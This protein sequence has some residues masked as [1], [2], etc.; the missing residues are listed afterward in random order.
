MKQDYRI[1]YID[2]NRRQLFVGEQPEGGWCGYT[3]TGKETPRRLRCGYMD[4]D[5]YTTYEEAQKAL[6]LYIANARQERYGNWEV[7]VNGKYVDWDE[8]G[9]IKMGR[10]PAPALQPPDALVTLANVEYRI[11]VH[12]QGAYENL[13]EVGKALLE[14]KSLNLVPH[15]QWE[16]WVEKNTGMSERSAQ[17]LMQAARST[18]SG[19]MMSK[20]P[21][22]KIQA[23]LALPEED[24]EPMA[25]KAVTENLS[26][27]QLQDEIRAQKDRIAALEGINKRA[28]ERANQSESNAR[29]ARVMADKAI[30]KAQEAERER[31]EARMAMEEMAGETPAAPATGISAEAQAMIDS[32]ERE[33]GQLSAQLAD[34]EKMAEYQARQREEAQQQLLDLRTQAARG[35]G[36]A[37]EDLTAEAVSMA[38]RTFIGCVGYVPHSDKLLTLREGD[39]QEI[40]AWAETLQRW[41]AD[42]LRVIDSARQAVVIEGV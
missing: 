3:Q 42:V 28:N 24:R 35:E 11:A 5:G 7:L 23:I 10:M 33:K 25:E 39:R 14:A 6:D 2:P 21:V 8:L 20:L 40:V 37:Q 41:S 17:R 34:A 16:A 4:R 30:K 32:L 31:D 18:P 38:A 36:P 26:L 9:Q 22:S 13:L 27:R 29:Q 1:V 15:G 12:I 19:S